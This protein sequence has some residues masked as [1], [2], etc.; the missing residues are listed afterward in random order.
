YTTFL[1]TAN[2]TFNNAMSNFN[3][4]YASK[5][6]EAEKELSDQ[7]EENQATFDTWFDSIKDSID[8]DEALHLQNQINVLDEAVFN[9]KLEADGNMYS[10]KATD[11]GIEV[12]KVEGA[13]SQGS[14]PSPDNPQEMQ[15]VEISELKSSGRNM[16][17]YQSIVNEAT[18]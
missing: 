6:A 11:F 18:D 3:S 4:G 15:A 2:T 16:F 5:L 14:N 10:G 8:E 13:Y 9:T 17:D 12:G 7:L 1:Q